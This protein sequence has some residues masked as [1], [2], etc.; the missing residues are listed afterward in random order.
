MALFHIAWYQYP[1]ITPYQSEDTSQCA[2]KEL[3]GS[4]QLKQGFR[5]SL[6]EQLHSDIWGVKEAVLTQVFVPCLRQLKNHHSAEALVWLQR[7]HQRGRVS[8]MTGC[9]PSNIAACIVVFGAANP[10]C[11]LL[12]RKVSESFPWFLIFCL[13][14]AKQSRSIKD[15]WTKFFY[16]KALSLWG[17]R[18]ETPKRQ[19][20]VA[21]ASLT[22]NC[23]RWVEYLTWIKLEAFPCFWVFLSCLISKLCWLCCQMLQYKWLYNGAAL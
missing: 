12:R 17:I 21:A 22:C 2:S 9:R 1:L 13:D 20:E 23:L 15:W 7:K 4:R 5:G 16:I 10:C 19:M 6:N 18:S 11:L 3:I 8:L 14:S